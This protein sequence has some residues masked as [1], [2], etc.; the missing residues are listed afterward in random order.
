MNELA[1]ELDAQPIAD[2]TMH[3]LEVATEAGTVA[4][5]VCRQPQ[6][7]DLLLAD[8]VERQ[9]LREQAAVLGFTRIEVTTSRIGPVEA[10]ETRIRYREDEIDGYQTDLHC[11]H[12]GVWFRIGATSELRARE[13]ADACLSR[14]AATLAFRD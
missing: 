12:G 13:A 5:V 14:V 9:L 7:R 6:P 2:K 4:L 8:A 1:F 11:F 3:R 10:I